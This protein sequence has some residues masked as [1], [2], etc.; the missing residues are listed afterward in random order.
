MIRLVQKKIPGLVNPYLIRLVVFLITIAFLVGC[1]NQSDAI[2]QI[3]VSN[4]NVKYI[5][6]DKGIALNIPTYDGSNQA[7]HPDILPLENIPGLFSKYKYLMA[8]TPYPNTMEQFENPSVIGSK[9]GLNFSNPANSINP[10]APTPIDGHNAD[11]DLIFDHRTRQFYLYYIESHAHIAQNVV[12]LTSTDLK[13]W[14]RQ[15]IIQDPI[16]GNPRFIVSPTVIK[17]DEGLWYMYYVNANSRRLEY[18]TSEDGISW[19]KDDVHLP[20]VNQSMS[21]SPWHAD[22]FRD[23][24]WYYVL[25]CGYTENRNL[26]IGRSQDLVNWEFK[27]E[28]ILTPLSSG[29]NCS[30]IYRSSGMVLDHDL[31]IYFSYVYSGNKWNIGVYRKKLSSIDFSSK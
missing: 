2:F 22:V 30:W 28:P 10:L 3:D 16:N 12:L 17:D 8:M 21:F 18:L 27:S 13:N 15:T 1:D 6:R 14:T 24:S 26:F 20:E 11:P 29:L 23:G 25:S 9:N 31:Y 4:I 5:P 19:D 7:V